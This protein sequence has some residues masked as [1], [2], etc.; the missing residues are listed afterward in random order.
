MEPINDDNDLKW[1]SITL[2]MMKLKSWILQKKMPTA[3]MHDLIFNKPTYASVKYDGTNVGLDTDGVMYGRNKK[4]AK[5]TKSYQKTPLTGVHQIDANLILDKICSSTEIK[6]DTIDTFVVYGELMCNNDL[7][8]Y[9]TEKIDGTFQIFGAVIKPK[10][11][12]ALAS[13]S[14]QLIKGSFAMRLADASGADDLSEEEDTEGIPA[15]KVI[16]ISMNQTYKD[17]LLGLG[18][19]VVPTADKVGTLYDVVMG[20]CDWMTGGY[21]EGLILSMPAYGE[22]VNCIK[23]KIGAEANQINSGILHDILLLIDDDKSRDL[24][25]DNTERAIE[26]FKALERI[27][28]SPLV[29]GAIPVVVVKTKAPVAKKNAAAKVDLT[30]AVWEKYGEPLKSAKTKFDHADV[31]FGKGQK[32]LDEY[33]GLISKECLTDIKIDSA[34]EAANSEHTAIITMI[35]KM[36]FIEFKKTQGGG[37]GGKKSKK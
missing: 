2:L 9:S 16:A 37:K 19:P 34:D 36:E 22:A 11:P 28:D 30:A 18:Y 35:I 14:E 1:P 25:G 33:I 26:F 24:F 23:W 3:T 8:D 32:G 29:M 7:Y 5:G 17:L 31:Y 13:I 12:E 27:C 6:R 4:I 21:G 10:D 20:N 15:T